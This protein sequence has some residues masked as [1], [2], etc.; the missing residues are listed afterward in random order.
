MGHALE[1]SSRST[2]QAG[3]FGRKAAVDLTTEYDYIIVG[4]G[5]AGCVLANRL[6]A[7][8]D[9]RVLVIEAGKD[10]SHKEMKVKVPVGLLKILRGELD[11]N[12]NTAS[13]DS[14]AG[15]EVYLCRG[16]ALGGSSCTNVM[17][18]NRGAAG[19]YDN[20]AAECGDETWNAAN[21]L[22]FFKKA[23]DCHAKTASRECAQMP[24]Y[25]HLI[26]V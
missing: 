7:K 11:W 4:G 12:Y 6:S 26:F 24:F 23:E 20:W 2:V 10:K 25:P 18:Y 16:K 19:D 5:T 22:P 1:R 3:L 14:V 9:A 15:R 21:M 8:P 17:L 13:T